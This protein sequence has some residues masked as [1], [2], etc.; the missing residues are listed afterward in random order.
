M[1]VI[2]YP[3]KPSSAK[4]KGRVLQQKVRDLILEAFP[5]LE[6]DD[7]RSTGMGQ[8][9]ADI[10][11]SPAAQKLFTFAVECKNQERVSLW[12]SYDQACSNAGKLEPLLIIKKNKRKPLAIIDLEKFMELIKSL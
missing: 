2:M 12:D 5:Q 7:V 4:A 1:S 10:Q 9:G 11:L 8:S 6:P 3:V